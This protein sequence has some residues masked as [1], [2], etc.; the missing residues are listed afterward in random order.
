[1]L[2]FSEEL[3]KTGGIF[4]NDIKPSNLILQK[5]ANCNNKYC[6]KMID[7]GTSTLVSNFKDYGSLGFTD[8]Y[9]LP[10]AINIYNNDPDQLT[11][12]IC[13]YSEM[14]CIARTL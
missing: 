5:I 3:Y 2:K 12:E 4:H 13:L 10:L 1:M 11:E 6:L 8:A 9:L 7:L 14:W